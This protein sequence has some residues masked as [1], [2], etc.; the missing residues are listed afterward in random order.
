MPSAGQ[1]RVGAGESRIHPRY[2]IHL[3]IEVRD[4]CGDGRTVAVNGVTVNV[5]RGGIL[6]LLENEIA[7]GA[8][9]DCLVRFVDGSGVVEPQLR[10]GT[11]VH[12][13]QVANGYEV[14][15][16]FLAPLRILK[17]G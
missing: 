6:V 15:I 12:S 8:A 4:R 13:E 14:T 11:A 10:W 7:T 17:H 1:Q 5:S 9:S 16:R 3:L 2:A